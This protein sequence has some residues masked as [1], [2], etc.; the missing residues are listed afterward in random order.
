MNTNSKRYYKTLTNCRF[1][2]GICMML[3]F[4]LNLTTSCNNDD[5]VM[6]I[7][8]GGGKTWKLTYISRDGSNQWYDFWGDNEAARKASETAMDNENNFVLNFEGGTSGTTTGG[9]MNGR[10]ITT[11]F[12]GSWTVTE[13]RSLAEVSG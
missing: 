8:V 11:P 3:C 5:D 12:N 7:F 13:G 10:G 6:D 9:A 2:V 1:M 4:I